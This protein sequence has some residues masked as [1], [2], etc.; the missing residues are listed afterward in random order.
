MLTRIISNGG[1]QDWDKIVVDTKDDAEGQMDD[2]AQKF[3]M[4]AN[5][6]KQQAGINDIPQQPDPNELEGQTMMG[7][8]N[9]ISY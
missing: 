8:Q 5:A 2:T 1:I 7:G 3:E 4:V 6:I 9:G